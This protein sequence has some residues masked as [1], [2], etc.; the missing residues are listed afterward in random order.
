M[1][2]FVGRFA[3]PAFIG[4]AGF[5]VAFRGWIAFYSSKSA[6]IMMAKPFPG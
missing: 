4:A 3:P 5:P 1:L 2:G 6:W